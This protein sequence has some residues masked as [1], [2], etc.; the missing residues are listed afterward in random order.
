M[1]LSAI[2]AQFAPAEAASIAI[3]P[4]GDGN[5]NDTYRVDYQ[6]KGESLSFL[7]QRLN[8]QVFRQPDEVA[9]NI[10]A[11]SGYLQHRSDYLLK[12][13]NPMLTRAGS[14]FHRSET[15]DYW[16]AFPFF[17]NTIAPERLPNADQ[18]YEA[19]K[20][21]GMFLCALRDF[22]ADTLYE[23]LPGFHDTDRRIDYFLQTIAA[24]PVGRCAATAADIDQMLAARPIFAEIS[25]LKTSGLLPRRVTHNDTKAGN[26]L[27]DQATGRAVAVIDWDTVMPGTVLSDFGDMART[28]TSDRYEDDPAEGLVIRREPL[29]ALQQ[30]F[31]ETTEGLLAKSERESLW[32]G[33]QWIIGE[34]ALRFLADYLASDVY[35]KI[36][37]PEH[38]LVR[39]RNQLALLEAL[40]RENI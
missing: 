5:I 34:Q 31:L 8:V 38:N 7:L 40:K 27:L 39:A 20:A 11:L 35:Y 30:G 10:S 18:A 17:H 12:V 4:I 9:A 32:L 6:E 1:S 15:G 3:N 23:V 37:Y 24:D 14:V 13:L 19:A 22:P 21:Y 2:A 25:R 28:F 33:A 36:A 29:Q 16:R 26:V